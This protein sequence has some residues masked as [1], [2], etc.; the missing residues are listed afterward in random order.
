MLL[1]PFA[2]IA[3]GVHGFSHLAPSRTVQQPVGTA[4]SGADLPTG[5]ATLARAPD[6]GSDRGHAGRDA[7]HRGLGDCP[8][9]LA[10][11]SLLGG[12]MA[13]QVPAVACATPDACFTPARP[14]RAVARERWPRYQGRAPPLAS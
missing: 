13:P 11:A 4:A 2:Q 3:A 8:L 1:L 9:C 14:V 5:S 6:G 7:P 12:A 10:G